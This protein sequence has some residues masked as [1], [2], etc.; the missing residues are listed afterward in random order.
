MV[1]AAFFL[2]LISSLHCVGMCAPLMLALSPKVATTHFFSNQVYYQG[3]RIAVYAFLGYLLP[4]AIII[5]KLKLV[6]VVIAFTFGALMLVYT[7]F[8]AFKPHLLTSLTANVGF[9][10]FHKISFNQIKSTK[11]R[12]LA[13]GIMNGFIP[14]G[15]IYVALAGAAVANSASQGSLFMF[16]FGLGTIPLLAILLW[17]QN[18]LKQWSKHWHKIQITVLLIAAF[19]MF[20]RGIALYKNY[21]LNLSQTQTNCN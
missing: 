3:G 19:F 5:T 12:H 14:C 21:T 16:L 10:F 1:V 18:S 17:G 7:F 11:L 13:F 20:Y 9:R 4:G 6:A 2:G 8:L 15:M